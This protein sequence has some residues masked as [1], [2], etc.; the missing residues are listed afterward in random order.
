VTEATLP[1]PQPGTWQ[2]TDNNIGATWSGYPGTLASGTLAS[3]SFEAFMIKRCDFVTRWLRDARRQDD[4]VTPGVTM[5]G[6]QG[7][8]VGRCLR[9]VRH[10][11][12]DSLFCAQALTR[13]GAMT[14][15]ACLPAPSF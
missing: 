3:L 2:V 4:F 9:H 14:I 15:R 12:Y 6:R 7:D 10:A 13:K 8:P 5:S 11:P 1:D